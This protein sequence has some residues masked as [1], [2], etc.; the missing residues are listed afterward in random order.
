MD[1]DEPQ[2][3]GRWIDNEHIDATTQV[4]RGAVAG[5]LSAPNIA[6]GLHRWYYGG[7]GPDPIVVATL[8]EWDAEIAGCGLAPPP[9]F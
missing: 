8:D 2:L 6:F 7:S 5:V 1:H 3:P 9:E 4:N